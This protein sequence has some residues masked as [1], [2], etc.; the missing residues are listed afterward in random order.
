MNLLATIV[1]GGTDFAGT[2]FCLANDLDFSGVSFVP[3]GLSG[4]FNGTFDG[5][6][7]TISGINIDDYVAGGVF[8]QMGGTVKNLRLA[9]STIIGGKDTGGIVSTNYGT[10]KNCKV[11]D[12][13]TV[14]AADYFQNFGGAIRN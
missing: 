12:D 13:V 9:N 2:Y 1:N 3:V 11:A 4:E 7:K 8:G 10:V 5:Q 6:G 14:K